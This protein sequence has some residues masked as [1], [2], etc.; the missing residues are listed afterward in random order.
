MRGLLVL[1]AGLIAM[2]AAAQ[3]PSQVCRVACRVGQ[4]TPSPEQRQCLAQ[5]ATGQPITR[6][7]PGQARPSGAQAVSPGQTPPPPRSA[8]G[9]PPPGNRAAAAPAVRPSQSSYGAVY[10]AIPPNMAYGMAVGQRDRL[11]AHRLA[12]TA[13]RAAGANC[14]MA[15][16]LREA[17]AAVAEGVRRAPGAFFMTSDPKTYVV[18]AITF[19]SGGNRADA[20]R[21]ALDVCRQRERGALT[22]RIVQ[23]QCAR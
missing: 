15:E 12:E 20:E 16:D 21:E 18:R 11:A 5:C 7:S 6:E 14:V 13:C 9:T 19:R 1:L 3:Q 4:A 8:A 22:C 2:P 10:L 17:C 23:A